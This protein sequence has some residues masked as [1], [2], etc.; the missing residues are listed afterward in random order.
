MT[1]ETLC[2]GTRCSAASARS[3]NGSSPAW[4]PLVSLPFDDFDEAI[5][6]ANDTEYGLAIYEYTQVKTVSLDLGPF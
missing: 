2:P 5:T 1:S 3:S 4:T 6:L